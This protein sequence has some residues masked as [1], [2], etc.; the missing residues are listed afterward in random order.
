MKRDLRRAKEDWR[1][2]AE[3]RKNGEK[4]MAKLLSAG[5]T[6]RTVLSNLRYLYCAFVVVWPLTNFPKHV[7]M[8]F[9]YPFKRDHGVVELK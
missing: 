8:S 1:T 4:L 9:P 5:A 3:D 7:D 6:E 2:K